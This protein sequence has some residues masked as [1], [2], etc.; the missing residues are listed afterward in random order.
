[1]RNG[2]LWSNVVFEK[3]VFSYLNIN[4]LQPWTLIRHLKAHTFVQQG[5]FFFHYS[6]ATLMTNWVK[7]FADL[8]CWDTP[9]EN[10][11]LWQLPNVYSAFK[12][13]V[14]KKVNYAFVSLLLSSM[15][16]WFYIV[17]VSRWCKMCFEEERTHHPQHV[18]DCLFIVKKIITTKKW[19]CVFNPIADLSFSKAK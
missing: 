6:L 10:T 11:G 8:S 7:M 18:L 16:I 19:P 13:F 14:S 15:G 3:Q 12:G 17:M 1:M 5:W 2:S 4:R 9:S